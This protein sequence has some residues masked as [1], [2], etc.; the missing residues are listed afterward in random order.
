VVLPSA[1]GLR[2]ARS[3]QSGGVNPKNETVKEDTL[4]RKGN[5]EWQRDGIRNIFDVAVR[6][7][8]A[9]LFSVHRTAQLMLRS[10]L[11]CAVLFALVRCSFSN[12]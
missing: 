1:E 2:A 10:L 6:S 12:G 5:C 7:H 9:V 8:A 4:C 11:R 3:S